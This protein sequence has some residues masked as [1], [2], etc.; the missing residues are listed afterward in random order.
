MPDQRELPF[1]FPDLSPEIPFIPVRM[2]NEYVYC[3]RLAYLEW[4]QGASASL[5]QPRA[6]GHARHSHWFSEARV[7]RP[8]LKLDSLGAPR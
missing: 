7:P 6:Q 2:A 8:S 5:K 1:S 4:V 3:P